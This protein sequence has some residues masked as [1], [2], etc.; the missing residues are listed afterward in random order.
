[1]FSYHKLFA[2]DSFKVDSSS[3]T[4]DLFNTDLNSLWWP[5]P[6]KTKKDTIYAELPLL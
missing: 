3:F 1:M 5:P 6:I 4:A 2:V